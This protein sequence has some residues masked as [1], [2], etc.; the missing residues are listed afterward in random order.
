MQSK[1]ITSFLINTPGPYGL[2]NVVVVLRFV[3]GGVGLRMFKLTND[4]VDIFNSHGKLLSSLEIDHY[5]FKNSDSLRKITDIDS[6]VI[7]IE[8]SSPQYLSKIALKSSSVCSILF[9]KI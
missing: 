5:L 9:A 4:A 7:M 1:V 3:A 2:T 6:S 8:V